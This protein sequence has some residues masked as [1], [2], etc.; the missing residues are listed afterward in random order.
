MCGFDLIRSDRQGKRGGGAAIY[1]RASVHYKITDAQKGLGTEIE[2]CFVDLPL[3]QLCVLCVY[4]PPQLSADSLHQTKESIINAVDDHLSRFPNRRVIILGDFNA[5]NVKSLCVDLNLI[6]IVEVP[7]RGNNILDH[8]LVSEDINAAYHSSF[9]SLEAPVGRSDHSTIIVTPPCTLL[10]MCSSRSHLVFDYRSSNVANLIEKAKETDWM[11][12]ARF[13]DDV[14]SQ[15]SKLH[16]MILNLLSSCVPHKLV[17]LSSHDKPWMT[18]VTKLLLEQKWMAFRSKDWQQF[19]QLKEKLKLEIR[20]AKQ[21]WANKLKQRSDGLWKLTQQLSGK[22]TTNG[23]DGLVAQYSSPRHLAEVIAHSLS[24]DPTPDG[25]LIVDDRVDGSQWSPK[26]TTDEIYRQLRSLKSSKAAGSD[27]IPSKVYC[28]LAPFLAAPL[29]TIFDTSIRKKVFPTEWKK[30]I[31]VPVPK[32]RP[33]LLHKLRMI[34]LLP[35]PAK[36]LEK[37]ILKSIIHHLEPLYERH[38]HAFRKNASTTTALVQITDTITSLYDN[39]STAGM[40]VL[41]LDFSKAF[42]NVDHKTLL[43]KISSIPALKGFQCWLASYLCERHFS[44]R[45][46]GQLSSL[47]P[48]HVGVP[49]GSVLGPT[50]FSVLVGDLPDSSVNNNAFVQFADDVNIILEFKSIEAEAIHSKVQTQLSQVEEWCSS[51]HQVLNVDKTRLLLITRKPLREDLELPVPTTKTL[52]ILGVHLSNTLQWDFHVSEAV[53]RASQRL[54]ILRMLKPFTS[55][56]ELHDIY[57]ANI[58]CLF[59]YCCPAFPKLSK[60]STGRIKRAEKRAHRIIFGE[61]SNCKCL[62]DGLTKRRERLSLKLYHKI[63]S[64]SH[65]LLYAKMPRQLPHMRQSNIYCRTS[66]RQHSFFPYVTLLH[67]S[68]PILPPRTL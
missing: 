6:D 66:T 17:K 50:L 14:D 8:V 49:Q 54:H 63:L 43:Q 4:L 46:G 44:V 52:K 1:I 62:L 68:Q 7:T 21:L 5:F 59:D 24:T 20:K 27:N 33:P 18:P 41:S 57:K 35:V 42:D 51:N 61:H 2:G 30:G 40:G 29:K 45:V 19:S 64:N 22:S 32:T 10:Q 28:L 26:V 15:W 16:H 12:I 58:R 31:V 48:V 3:L 36:V 25:K 67:N 39:T 65:H 55:S 53:K 9:L 11:S 56:H 38:Q 23:L 60:K 34:T 37:L 13:E 47:Y